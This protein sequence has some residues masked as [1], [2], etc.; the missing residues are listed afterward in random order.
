MCTWV[1]RLK[2]I[3]TINLF[4]E[5]WEL[6]TMSDEIKNVFISHIHEDDEG[7]DKLKALVEGKGL[8]IRD[9]SITSERPNQAT[10]PDYIKQNILKP[11]I[12]W[13]SVLVVYISPET[14]D[15]E[16]VNWEIEYAL[17][18]D[19]RLVGVWA[20]GDSECEVPELI[21][22]HAN[23]IVG[24]NG[25]SIVDAI[26]GESNESYGQTGSKNYRDIERYSC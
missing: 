26:T 24:W 20:W 7:L 9:S 21:D 15:S 11:G 6:I 4:E 14:K 12:D 5:P 23:A 18:Q 22:K 1:E 13:A 2:I 10:D 25:E 17:E 19:K 3:Y 8:T 16:W